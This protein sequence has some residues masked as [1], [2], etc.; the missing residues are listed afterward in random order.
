MSMQAAKIAQHTANRVNTSFPAKS[1][2]ALLVSSTHNATHAK[3]KNNNPIFNCKGNILA[4][5]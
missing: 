3:S 1:S 4:C 2:Q 5:P